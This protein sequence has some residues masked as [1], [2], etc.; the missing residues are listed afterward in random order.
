MAPPFLISNISLT[1]Q[2]CKT[3]NTDERIILRSISAGKHFYIQK[4]SIF[5]ND[6]ELGIVYEQV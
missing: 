4:Y 6:R 5:A 1:L 3:L 2:R